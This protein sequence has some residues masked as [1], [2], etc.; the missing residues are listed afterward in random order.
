MVMQNILIDANIIQD[1]IDPTR[2]QESSLRIFDLIEKKQVRGSIASFSVTTIWYLN[3]KTI[4]EILLVLS[5]LL[6]KT[7]LIDLDT[8]SLHTA[9]QKCTWSD[10][11]DYL[12]YLCAKKV[13]AHY[14]ITRNTKDFL[15]SDIPVKTPEEFLEIIKTT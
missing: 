12:Q 14:I 4:T 11:E 3:R 15:A 9:L 6:E 5:A 2:G 10:F 8:T 1:C 13:D 7:H